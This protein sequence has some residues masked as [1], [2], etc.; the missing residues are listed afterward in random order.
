MI[1]Q[2]QESYAAEHTYC[3]DIETG[4]L[5]QCHELAQNSEVFTKIFIS[6]NFHEFERFSVRD[7]RQF[8]FG[9]KFEKMT[10]LESRENNN[11]S[12]SSLNSADQRRQVLH[13]PTWKKVLGGF[14]QETVLGRSSTEKVTSLES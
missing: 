8:W 6:I 12:L 1:R 14:E 4:R 13:F 7:R 5:T 3:K 10:S 11:P 2:T 9:G